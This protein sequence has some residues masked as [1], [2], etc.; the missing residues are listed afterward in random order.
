MEDDPLECE[1][2][3]FLMTV[4]SKLMGQEVSTKQEW[5]VTK[6]VLFCGLVWT[7]YGVTIGETAVTDLTGILLK[8]TAGIKQ[9]RML[10]GVVV[11]ARSAFRFSAG[12]LLKFGK[13]VAAASAV[14]EA[15]TDTGTRVQMDPRGSCS[16]FRTSRKTVKTTQSLYQ[17]SA[18]DC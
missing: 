15:Q 3:P 18:L 17:P 2:K 8:Q 6:E 1:I 4:V 9:I 11:Q 13:R 16:C 12:E 5:K 7:V 14:V 10:R